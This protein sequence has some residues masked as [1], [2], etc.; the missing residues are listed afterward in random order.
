MKKL[1]ATIAVVTLF[2]SAGTEPVQAGSGKDVIFTFTVQVTP[3][4][5][6]VGNKWK[7]VASY[8]KKTTAQKMARRVRAKHP[9]LNVRVKQKN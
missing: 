2:L 5:N 7:T 4:N 1:C 3:R 6:R 9:W 8:K